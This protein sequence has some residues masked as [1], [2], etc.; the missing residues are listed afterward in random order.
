MNRYK[1]DGFGAEVVKI[2]LHGLLL[3]IAATLAAIGVFA[4][5]RL[6]FREAENPTREQVTEYIETHGGSAPPASW[7]P[8]GDPWRNFTAKEANEMLKDCEDTPSNRKVWRQV[9]EPV[10]L[11][12]GI[13]DGYELVDE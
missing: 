1:D 2:F 10:Q 3:G 12:G 7:Y 11:G 5:L 13:D 4:L 9:R 6:S 8:S